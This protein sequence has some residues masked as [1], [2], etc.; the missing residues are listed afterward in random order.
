MNRHSTSE[1]IKATL[2][3]LRERIPGMH[4][5]TTF[6]VGFPGETDEDYNELADF[7]EE[8]KF[9][10]LGVFAYSREEGTPA[11][12]MP[13]Q[14]DEDIKEHRR[15]EIMAIQREISL[16]GNIAKVGRTLRVLVEEHCED[17]TYMGRT[18]YDAPDIDDGVIFTSDAELEPGTFVNVE[19]TDAFDYDLTGKA[20]I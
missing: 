14:V 13:D 19:I 6:I 16:A 12:E 17:G 15:D 20:V 4:I 1:S 5:R 8:Q 10:R 11:A 2:K 18:E 9:D 7:I 3:K